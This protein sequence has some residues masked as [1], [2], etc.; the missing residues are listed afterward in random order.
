MAEQDFFGDRGFSGEPVYLTDMERCTP[1]EAIGRESVRGSVA[2]Y[3]YET[4]GFDG[5]L[6]MAGPETEAPDIAYPLD[7]TGWHAVSIGI[8]PTDGGQSRQSGCWRS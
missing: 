5:V 2:G 7:V 3:D 8:H 4:A 1:S 6:L